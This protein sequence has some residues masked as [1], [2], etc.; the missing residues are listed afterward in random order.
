[1]EDY[2]RIKS[3]LKGSDMVF[4]TAGEGGGTGT[5][6]APVVARIARE[7]GALTVGIVTKP[8]G[9]E[10]S[11]RLQAAESG[12][13]ALAEEVDTLIVVPNNRLLSVL[14]KQ[15]SM[16]EAFRVA[17]DVLR[18]GV[19]GISD[20]ITLPGLINLDFADVRTIMSDA[21]NALLGIGM[22]TGDKRAVEAAEQATSSPL[23]ETTLEGAQGDPAVDHRRRATCRCGR[24]TRRPAPS[25]RPRTRTRTSSSARWSTRSSRTRCGSRSSPPATTRARAAPRPSASDAWR[26]PAGEPRVRAHARAARGAALARRRRRAGVHPAVLSRRPA[27]QRRP[28]RGVVA[29]GHPL[30][31]A[32]GADVLRAGGNAVDAALAAM[33]TSFVTEPLLTG[34]GAGGYMLVAPPGGEPVLLDFFVAAPG[35]GATPAR[36]LDAPSTSPSAT[37]CRCSTSAPRRAAS[38]ACPAG[39]R[40]GGRALRHDAAGRARR[41]RRRARPRR[42]SRS[43]P[44]RRYLFEILAPIAERTAES[45]ARFMPDGRAPRAGDVLARPGARRRARAARRRGRR[46]RSTPATSAAAVV[47]WVRERGGTLTREDLAALR[48]RSPREPVRVAYHGREVLTNPPPSAGGMLIAYALALLERGAGPPD[49]RE[50][51]AR[52][53]GRAGRAHAGVPRRARRAGLPG[54]VHGQPARLDDAHLGA[55]RRRLG[56]R[57]DVHQRRGLRASSCPAPASTS[58]T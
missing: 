46:R 12:I 51:V 22:G 14:D 38:T 15:T 41:A 29:A 3:L 8:F 45:R 11:R 39:V 40:G 6:A 28:W 30:T 50:L 26:E 33:L 9:F 57:G 4:I 16:M 53:G 21:G 19:Q 2:D 55:R 5:G 48:G 1:M 37:R 17:D 44:S 20:L 10:G 23:L 54:A 18:Q 25:R 32:A 31:A 56:V 47:D 35:H 58:T 36:A 42:A 43:T 34:L 24:S 27:S 13:E 49:A 7:L 52:D